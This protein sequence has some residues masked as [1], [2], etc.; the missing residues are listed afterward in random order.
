MSMWLEVLF[1]IEIAVMVLCIISAR[2]SEKKMVSA[3]D[4]R[5]D[6]G[7]RQLCHFTIHI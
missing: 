5:T 4:I 7:L 1:K 3:F 2:R 6:C